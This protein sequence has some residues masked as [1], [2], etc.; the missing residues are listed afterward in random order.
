MKEDVGPHAPW[1]RQPPCQAAAVVVSPGGGEVRAV[2]GSRDFAASSF[3]R[4]TDARRA[5]GSAFK[6]AVYLAA[7]DRGLLRADSVLVDEDVLFRKETSGA[8]RV[9]PRGELDAELAQR[10]DALR[11][12]Y[13]TGVEPAG[14]LEE[15]DSGAGEVGWAVPRGSVQRLLSA[16]RGAGNAGVSWQR[17]RAGGGD[18]GDEGPGLLEGDYTPA[19]YSR[20]F[21][22]RVTARQ[23]LA[24]SLN[25]PTV[26]VGTAVG[27]DA[28]AGLA[29]RLGVRSPLRATLSLCLGASEMAPVELAAVFNAVGARG[30]ASPLHCVVCV[31]DASGEVMARAAHAR[32]RV[33]SA[34]ACRELHACLVEAAGRS[35]GRDL[36]RGWGA[37]QVAGKTGTSDAYRCGVSAGR[38]GVTPTCMVA[39]QRT[40]ARCG[41]RCAAGTR[42]SPATPPRPPVSSGAGTMMAP[43]SPGRGP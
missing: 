38:C 23:A 21:R 16:R 11:R 3:N 42:G 24:E 37:G 28:V 35:L 10:D 29:R 6:P 15:G 2:V 1:R 26:K 4:A 41:F 9:M 25:I 33:V 30:F 27:V 31:E 14:T 18:D 40:R 5:P 34:H 12:R 7:F 32:E 39:Q 13:L 43:R 8:W 20:G 17:V 22:G 19:N 36:L